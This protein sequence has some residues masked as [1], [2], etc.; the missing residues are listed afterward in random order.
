LLPQ[1]VPID[2]STELDDGLFREMRE[3]YPA[4]MQAEREAAERKQRDGE[5]HQRAMDLVFGAP[6]FLAA[7][8]LADF[9]KKE[10]AGQMP[11]FEGGKAA[12]ASRSFIS[13]ALGGP[14]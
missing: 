4:R 14:S 1:L 5:A 6:G 11:S 3:S 9:W 8:E 7:P 13:R 12:G 2:R 10:V